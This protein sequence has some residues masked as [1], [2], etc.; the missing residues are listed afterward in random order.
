MRP[1]KQIIIIILFIS[2]IIAVVVIKLSVKASKLQ[3][4]I[5]VLSP[6]I[7]PTP[8][9]P[10]LSP[11]PSLPPQKLPESSLAKPMKLISRNIKSFS[12]SGN[13]AL[14]ADGDWDTRWVGTIPGWLA[15]DLSDI[16]VSER[17][18]V[19]LV[20][21]ND[22][23]TSIYDHS[24][25]KKSIGSVD[26]VGY[27]NLGAYTIQVNSAPGGDL[28]NG[29]WINMVTVSDNTYHSRQHLINLA[30]LNWIRINITGS[31]GNSSFVKAE[32]NM[33]LF[34]VSHGVSDDWLFLGDSVTEYTME[35]RTF[36]EV[37]PLSDLI[38]QET[39]NTFTPLYENGGI[40]GTVSR[41][42]ADN[43]HKWLKIFPGK[44]IVLSYGTNDNPNQEEPN[45]YYL[46]MEK[47]VRA[48]IAAG[49]ISVIPQILWNPDSN[50][51]DKN[52]QLNL[53]IDNLSKNYPQIIRGPDLW[54]TLY[55]NQYL[56]GDTIHPNAKGTAVIRQAWRDVLLKTVYI[57][58]SGG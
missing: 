26:S 24:Y 38:T 6:S 14:A 5:P 7:S 8:S 19:I 46:N 41:F 10:A 16:P 33:D 9:Y 4:P 12:S 20:W 28:P 56:F 50:S 13:A 1:G 47:M 30:G 23:V 27:N 55:N 11:L 54:R 34:D 52:I 51:Y 39:N 36:E 37:K 44:Y 58:A 49:K 43:I 57:K 42:G 22:P 32:I 31:D 40:G 29:G 45:N 3:A 25:Y 21:I 48:V 17:Q 2:V 15:Y 53:E 18:Q 35:H